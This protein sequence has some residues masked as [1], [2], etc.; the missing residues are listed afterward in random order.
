M[1]LLVYVAT[2]LTLSG[3][4]T[5][6]P[7]TG[8]LSI[9]PSKIRAGESVEVRVEAVNRGHEPI[10]VASG[11]P[12]TR[13]C[14]HFRVRIAGNGVTLQAPA[15]SE[16]PDIIGSCLYGGQNIA[17]G[18]KYTESFW[19]GR[20]GEFSQPGTYS[21]DVTYQLIYDNANTWPSPKSPGARFHSQFKVIVEKAAK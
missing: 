18:H 2:C 11:A 16:G 14:G 20:D 17:P 7:V 13:M 15:P 21:I 1:K 6:G 12:E 8:H 10:Q 4:S 9:N 5:L 19:I 3:Q